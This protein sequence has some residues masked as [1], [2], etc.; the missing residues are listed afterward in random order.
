MDNLALGLW[1]WVCKNVSYRA[2]NG[3][4][5]YF[6]DEVIGQRHGDCDDSTLLLVSMLRHFYSPDRVYAVVGTYRGLGHAWVE[7]DREILETT[8]TYAHA[9]PDPQ[10]YH[11]YA[12][13]NDVEVAELWPRAMT[14][15]FQLARNACQKLTL[16]AEVQR[17]K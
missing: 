5:W 4:F 1:D 2:D 10:N 9:V 13:F 11:A 6:P 8:Y 3:E 17:G 15:L 12:K 16:M 7:L 14:Q